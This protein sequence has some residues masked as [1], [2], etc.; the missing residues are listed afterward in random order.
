MKGNKTLEQT[1]DR[2]A[3]RD[4]QRNADLD[5][6]RGIEEQAVQH[7]MKL[8]PRDR[9][10]AAYHLTR[11]WKL[12]NEAGMRK[13]DFQDA[14]HSRLR[15][16]HGSRRE[17]R[18]NNWTLRRGEDPTTQPHLLDKYADSTTPQKALE[19]YL[20]GLAIAAEQCGEESGDWKLAMVRDLSIWSRVVAPNDV[21]PP[22]DRPAET[23]EILLKAL[24][25]EL[26]RRNRLDETFAAIRRMNCR[27]DMFNERL[28][29]TDA[30]CMQRIES[31]ISPVCEDT[32]YFEE[33]FPFPSFPLLRVPYFVAKAEFLLAPES[34]LQSWDAEYLA[35]GDGWLIGNLIRGHADGHSCIPADAPESRFAKGTLAWF[36]EIR[37]CIAPDGHGGYTSVLETRP[38]FEARFADDLPFGGRHHVVGG[39]ELDLERGL[40]YARNENGGP[41]WPHIC[42]TSGE[43]WRITIPKTPDGGL[44]LE[45][46]A[47]RDS[48]SPGWFFEA[49]PVLHAGEVHYEPWYLSYTPATAPYLRHWLTSAWH[50]AG[51]SA[52]C[53]WS[54]GNFDW[55]DPQSPWNKNLPPVH[56]LNFPDF[57][58]AT[59]IECCLHNG[60]IEDALQAKIDRLK[61]QTGRIQADWHAARE[62]NANAL[63]RR[64]KAKTD[65]ME[66]KE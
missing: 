38:Y 64:W 43:T 7:G 14:I 31:P 37:L 16:P 50:L 3:R 49:D 25:A 41:V 53:P 17:F 32:V 51:E 26:A 18:L 66:T 52:D 39:Y 1:S 24:C 13:E 2:D 62:R 19:P 9:L 15:R 65:S 22:D 47:E 8:G 12:A 48:A 54:R 58:H 57:S 59:W 35:R 34:A 6:L 42:L 29:A 46:W 63:L 11:A 40:F 20:V 56:E 45:E 4:E 61:E 33:M 60:L 28:V 30:A 44:P 5:K 10:K 36:R 23:L 55:D 27:W 21:A